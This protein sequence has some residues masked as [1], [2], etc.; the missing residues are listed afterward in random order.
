MRSALFVSHTAELGGAEIFLIDLLRGGPQQWRACFLSEGKAVEELKT[1]GSPPLTILAGKN[2]MSVRRGSAGGISVM[3]TAG[4]VL[5]IVKTAW[6]LS[7]Q[8][9]SF[10]II[11]ANSQ[12]SLFVS[13]LAAKLAHRP[14]VWILHDIITDSAFS[15]INRRAVMVFARYF[16]SLV[17]VNSIET[18]R[19]FVEAGG[20]AHKVRVVYNGFHM[21]RPQPLL[22]A[23]RAALRDELGFD[24]RP[25]VGLCGRLSH[26][27]GQH[28][29][30]S[31]LS[32]LNNVH[33]MIVGGALFGQKDY[34]AEIISL[35]HDLGLDDR[36]RFLG[37][38]HDVP[39]LMDAADIIVHTSVNPEPFGRVI[40][41]GM[42]A[43]RPVI[44]T[45]GGGVSEIVQDGVNGCLV[46]PDDAP[47]L[48]ELIDTLVKKPQFAQKIARTG[49]EGA[50]SRFS[51]ETTRTA[52]AR[53]LDECPPSKQ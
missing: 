2:M 47:A 29:L 34:E 45:R 49:Y 50:V 11:C 20:E 31:A 32:G 22:P 4:I 12:K 52:M 43:G 1:Y 24:S 36:V 40:V 23:Q 21:S 44:A 26:W 3:R 17:V 46:P 9:K 48:A 6:T 35:A 13:A 37:F 5:D 25:L 19:A 10:D 14:L 33:A 27:K 8:A 30:L 38:R 51:I 39:E 15:A 18:G 16:A 28:I 53:V 42:L 7:R 41:E